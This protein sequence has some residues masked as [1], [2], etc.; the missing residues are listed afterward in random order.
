M[1][2]RFKRDVAVDFRSARLQEWID[3]TFRKGE[4]VEGHVITS[5]M[6]S[7]ISFPNGDLAESVKT[8]S[9]EILA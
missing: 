2:L 6:W 9:F 7:D 8:D 4:T 5:G 1:K 3:H